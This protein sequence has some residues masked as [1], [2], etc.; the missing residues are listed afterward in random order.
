MAS[1]TEQLASE[2]QPLSGPLAGINICVVGA[3]FVGCVAAAGFAKFGHKVVCAEKDPERVAQLREGRLPFY[4]RSLEELIKVNLE[5]GRLTFSM[6]L[7]RSIEGQKAIFITVGTPPLETGRTDLGALEEVVGSLSEKLKPG[8]ILVIKSTVPVGTADRL[9]QILNR[10]GHP[11]NSIPIVNNPEFLREG[12]AVYD[13]FYPQR[14][15]IGGELAEAVEVVKHVYRLGMTR[16]VPIIVT[17]NRTAEMIKYA[18]NTFLATKIGFINELAV[19]CDKV[20]VNVLEVARAMGLD[21]RIGYEF[22]NPGPGWGGSCLPK[23]LKEFI[24]LADSH[25]ISMQILRAV[26]EANRKQQDYVASK[27]RQLV[28]KLEGSR[29]GVLGLTFKADTSDLRDSPAVGVIQRLVS[30]GAHVTAYDPAASI[31]EARLLTEAQIVSSPYDAADGADCLAILTEWPEFQLLD[32]RRIA[33]VMSQKNVVDARNVLSAEVL[34]RYDFT[35]V[36]LG[37]A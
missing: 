27:V 22:L 4:E 11:G 21:T 29:I 24:G 9:T 14:I 6:D 30:E 2:V 13:F 33:G 35:Y 16:P 32:W 23:D 1:G 7:E 3:G 26:D 36:S 18:S 31:K 10:N 37:Q 34:E 19:L 25:G 17:N 15:V 5:S 28:G 12:S 20:G 8:Q